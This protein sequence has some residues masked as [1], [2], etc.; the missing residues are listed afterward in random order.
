MTREEAIQILQ[1]YKDEIE[2]RIDKAN[3][4]DVKDVYRWQM[5]GFCMAIEAL[6]AETIP[7][8][9]ADKIGEERERL[10]E[11]VAELQEKNADRPHGEWYQIKDH[12]IMG[13]G[14]LWHCSICDYKVYQDSSKDY[15]TENFCPNCGAK[16]TPYKGGD[17]E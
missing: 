7:L 8:S 13:E 6:Q 16:M 9:V 1:I 2:Q 12:K 14:Y 10:Q 11:K 5:D 3:T 15:P 17:D 4:P